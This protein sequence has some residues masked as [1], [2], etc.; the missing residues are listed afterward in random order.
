MYKPA[1]RLVTA[2]CFTLLPNLIV[3]PEAQSAPTS[4]SARVVALQVVDE[5]FDN[6]AFEFSPF[7]QV[8]TTLHLLLT[9]D[10]KSLVEIDKDTSKITSFVD[11]RGTD[12]L[13]SP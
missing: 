8:G 9:S 3:A 12:L 5:Q 4:V 1:A 6:D 11:D 2:M 13:K 10:E 7:H